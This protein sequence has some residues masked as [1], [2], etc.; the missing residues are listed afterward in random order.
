MYRNKQPGEIIDNYKYLWHIEKAFRISKTDL[1]IRPIYHR[2]RGRIE[3]HICISFTA[4]AILK[5]MERILCKVKAP[6]SQTRAVE[7]TKTIYA[8]DYE[9]PDSKTKESI[10][11]GL[12][13]NQK[14]LINIFK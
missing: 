6:F 10:N 9:L 8:L 3:A 2:L 11:I 1:R 5:D 7:L 12:N 14:L 13:K 4:Y